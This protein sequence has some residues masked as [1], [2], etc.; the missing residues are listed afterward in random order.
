MARYVT[1][2]LLWAIPTVLVVTDPVASYHR[3][4]PRATAEKLQQYR[5][6]NGLVG[7]VPEQYFR[8][9]GHFVTGHW[10]T[11]IKGSRPVW[12]TM[13]DAMGNTLV[14]GTVAWLVGMTV[15]GAVG[16]IAALRPH[17][18]YDRITTTGAFVGVSI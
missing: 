15:G 1:R 14:L 10:G 11:S 8:W 7:S 9:L 5:Q 4:N 16:M 3:L 13:R 6:V 12:P 17:S 18:R 2:R